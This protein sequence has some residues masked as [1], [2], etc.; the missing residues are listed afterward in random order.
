MVCRPSFVDIPMDGCLEASQAENP[1][2]EM[3]AHRGKWFPTVIVVSHRAKCC[4]TVCLYS[5]DPTYWTK[6]FVL[7]EITTKC[8]SPQRDM[9]IY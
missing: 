6:S 8:L 3:I 1:T 5:A 2:V 9:H 4:P 7:K